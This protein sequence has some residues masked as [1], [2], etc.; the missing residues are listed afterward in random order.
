MAE[1]RDVHSFG[2]VPGPRHRNS[3]LIFLPLLNDTDL[4]IEEHVLVGGDGER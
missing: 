4:K 2:R 1:A 3:P